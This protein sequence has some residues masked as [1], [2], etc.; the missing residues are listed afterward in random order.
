MLLAELG[1]VEWTDDVSLAFGEIKAD[2]QRRGAPIEDLDVAIAAHAA[3]TG[4]TLVTDNVS[5]MRRIRGLL[6]E[7]WLQGSR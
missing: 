1:R 7:N 2:L 3:A 5:D 4:A 6:I